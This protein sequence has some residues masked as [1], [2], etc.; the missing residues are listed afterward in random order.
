[1]ADSI[2]ILSSSYFNNTACGNDC[3]SVQSLT[4]ASRTAAAT[5]INTAFISGVDITNSAGKGYNGGLEN[6]FRFHEN[7]GGIAINY[8]GSFVSLGTPVHAN[9]AWISPGTCATCSY[10]APTR[11]YDY[12]TFFNS[13]ANLPPM[14]PRFVYVQQVLFTEQFK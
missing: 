10:N 4:T 14:T 8:L 1:L 7:W 3:Q 2:N 5:T 9:G 12:D 6:Y 11:F 13:A